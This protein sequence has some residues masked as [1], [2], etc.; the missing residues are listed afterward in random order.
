MAPSA[1]REK[2]DF[3]AIAVLYAENNEKMKKDIKEKLKIE[4]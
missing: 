1:I 2:E 4:L 3:D